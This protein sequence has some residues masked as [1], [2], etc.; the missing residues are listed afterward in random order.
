M[1]TANLRSL[2]LVAAAYALTV[3]FAGCDSATKIVYRDR[4]PFNPPPD[5]AS[6]F[7]GYYDASVKQ[8]T[9][10]NCHSSYQAKWKTTKHAGAYA[11][12][13]ANPGAQAS[14]YGCHTVNGNGNAAS[15]TTVAYAKVADSA[16]FDVQ[17]ESCHGAGLTHVEGVG[18]GT[19]VRPLAKLAAGGAG[20]C[21]DCHTG[22]HN[23][24]AEEWAQ[25]GHA[26]V[27]ASRAGNASCK[28]CHDGRGALAAWGVEANYQERDVATAY[29]PTTCAV[30]H[31]PHGSSNEHQLRF[32]VSTQ[33]PEQNLCMK[34]HLRRYEPELTGYGTASPHAPQGAMLLGF[35]GWRPP[36]FVYDTARIFGSHATTANPKLCAGCHVG[37]FTVNDPLTGSFTFQATGHLFRPIPC[38][39]P[40]GKPTADKTC[41][42]T[43]TARSWQT[44]AASGCHASAAVAANAFGTVRARMK[45]Y[46]DQ[47]WIDTNGS[48]SMQASPTDAGLLPLVRSTQPTEWSGTDN[49]VS[50]AEGAEF[51]ARLCGEFG[52]GNSDNSKGIHNPFLCESLLIAT[53]NY[54]QS[55]YGVSVPL[56]DGQ[57]AVLAGPIGGEFNRSMHV[58]RTPPGK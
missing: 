25:S 45:F 38:L 23:P 33:D 56:R 30:C 32:A 19:V 40:T 18:Q 3:S 43:S 52:Q 2:L 31:N 1:R 46:A 35:A 21:A 27:N 10:G 34:C 39:D 37:R 4:A 50:P 36:G 15:G 47:L 9:C 14:C 8:T 58:S 12:L 20:T 7:L 42:Y 49:R 13:V 48:G 41:A 57:P 11:S 17:C 6:G 44:C 22:S 5:A 29:Q 51:N 24:F 16:Y 28:S 54:I 55:F 26:I 53:I